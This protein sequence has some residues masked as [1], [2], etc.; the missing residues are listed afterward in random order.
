MPPSV[1]SSED[2]RVLLM[3]RLYVRER[4]MTPRRDPGVKS[5]LV[6]DDDAVVPG[7]VSIAEHLVNRGMMERRFLDVST[8]CPF[9]ASARLL[10]QERCAHCGSANLVEQAILHHFRCGCQRPEA[11]SAPK[12]VTSYAQSASAGLINSATTTTV[13]APS[14]AAGHVA[15]F[16]ATPKSVSPVWTALPSLGPRTSAEAKCIRITSLDPAEPAL[17]RASCSQAPP[18]QKRISGSGL[19]RSRNGRRNF[20]IRRAYFPSG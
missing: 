20:V 3:A 11:D 19:P 7:A 2:A 13:L 6:Y 5:T 1:K 4:G 17:N 8:I 16:L 10:V 9:C 12:A 18:N 15:K 14:T